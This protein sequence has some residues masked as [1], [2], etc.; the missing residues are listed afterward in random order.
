VG[1]ENSGLTLAAVSFDPTADATG[2]QAIDGTGATVLSNTEIQVTTP[3]LLADDPGKADMTTNVTAVFDVTGVSGA[4]VDS[5]PGAPG[6]DVYEFT[7]PGTT[8]GPVGVSGPT[9]V[10]VGEPY[11]ASATATGTPVPTF[12]L[13]GAPTWLSI[14]ATTG[15]I[16]GSPSGAGTFTFTVDATNANGTTASA[17]QTLTV[18]PGT[19]ATDL[20]P[21]TPPSV[22]EGTPVTYTAAVSATSGLGPLGG[23]VHFRADGKAIAACPPVTLSATVTTATCTTDFTTVGT[24]VITAIYGS[25]PNFAGSQI[26]VKQPVTAPAA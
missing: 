16:A 5:T 17:L 8:P 22:V 7:G 25:D 18:T 1:F 9:T 15:T 11:A 2:A 21:T 12:A 10:V 24:F 20:A 6:S 23:Q 4:Q 19:T 3:N 14:N 13:V 26:T